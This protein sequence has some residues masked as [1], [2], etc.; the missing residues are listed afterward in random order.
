[1]ALARRRWA[2]ELLHF[3]FHRLRPSHWFGRSDSVDAQLRR[4]FGRELAMLRM[5]P[6]R[7]FLG[8]PLTARAAV[9]LFD[10]CPRNLFRGSARAFA[11]DPLARA[12]CHGA[13]RKGWDR[14]LTRQQRMFLL[15][16]LMHSEH[17]ADQRQSRRRF[18]ANGDASRTGFAAAHYQMVA[19]FGRFP[20]RNAV[21]GRR[22]TPAEERAIAGGHAW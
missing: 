17:I 22:S 6:A 21:L 2:A 15:L 9:L 8:D 14:R 19:R 7:E 20:H 3:W 18:A 11:T 10:Q 12:I 16:P 1:M 13:L 4:R 5:R